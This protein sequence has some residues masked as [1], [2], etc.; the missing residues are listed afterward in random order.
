M[1]QCQPLASCAKCMDSELLTF[2]HNSPDM[3]LPPLNSGG[4]AAAPAKTWYASSSGRFHC[5]AGFDITIP[6]LHTIPMKA[7]IL[8]GLDGYVPVPVERRFLITP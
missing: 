8:V 4:T 6:F 1:I 2:S 7:R 5:A 3:N